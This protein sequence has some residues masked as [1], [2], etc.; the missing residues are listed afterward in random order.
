MFVKKIK[1]RKELIASIYLFIDDAEIGIREKK[2][3][4]FRLSRKIICSRIG[5]A[6]FGTK[7]SLRQHLSKMIFGEG[8]KLYSWPK[9]KIRNEAVADIITRTIKR[10]HLLLPVGPTFIFVFPSFDDFVKYKMR[11]TA[12]FTPWKNTILLYINPSPGWEESLERT[13]A[14]EFN[15]AA[16]LTYRSK[17]PTLLGALI[18]EGLG[19]NFRADVIRNNSAPYDK[20]L[21]LTEGRKLFS[22]LENRLNSCSRKLRR[23]LF[24]GK[25]R[26]PLWAGY[27]LG[28]QIVRSFRKRN[29]T[30]SWLQ[31][32][33]L[34]PR[35]I[36]KNSE[37][38]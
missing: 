4:P 26:Y 37:F 7:K 31:I 38:N 10:C 8:S 12:G 5:Y 20:V 11:G 14:H 30:L 24:F 29:P 19:E 25:G 22:A 23:E 36:F 18:F 27:S 16:A 28:Y 9:I 21:T 15:H 13:T 2:E 6:G 3:F 17:W 1:N 34:S 33:N 35:A 32:L